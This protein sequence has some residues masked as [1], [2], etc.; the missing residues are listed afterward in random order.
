MKLQPWISKTVFGLTERK[1]YTPAIF[2]YIMLRE[3]IFEASELCGLISFRVK[4]GSPQACSLWEVSI[5]ESL[6]TAYQKKGGEYICA[7][8]MLVN[9]EIGKLPSVA[10]MEE[11]NK[12][13]VV[14]MMRARHSTFII[15]ALQ[16]EDG[17]GELP[18]GR[19]TLLLYAIICSTR[20]SILYSSCLANSLLQGCAR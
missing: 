10:Q 14:T 9:K 7:F 12:V 4:T 5:K 2:E 6:E 20:Y 13:Q 17:L 3:A 15:R 1:P 8:A 11:V 18:I 16:V 19:C